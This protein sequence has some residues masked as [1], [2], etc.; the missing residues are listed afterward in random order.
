MSLE[1]KPQILGEGRS[2]IVLKRGDIAIKVFTG[3]D[4]LTKL[5]NYIF[6]GAPNACVWN[7]DAAW[8]AHY[9]REIL[10]ELVEHWFDDKLRVARSQGVEWNDDFKAYELHT[11]FV[12][13]RPA[14]LH[15]PYSESREGELSDLVDNVMK[16]LQERLV[17]AGFDG[18]VWQAGKGNPVASNNF[19][20]E[21]KVDGGLHW[22]WIDIESGVPALFPLNP[23]ALFSFYIPKSIKHRHALFDDVDIEKLRDY[24]ENEKHSLGAERYYYLIKG[25]E[26]LAEHQEKWK[27]TRRVDRSIDYRFKKG[28]ITE[29]QRELYSNY[30]FVW[31]V[32][33]GARALWKG[34]DKILGDLPWRAFDKLTTIDYKEKML[35]FFRFIS[36]EQEG[37][38]GGLRS[39]LGKMLSKI[40]NTERFVALGVGWVPIAGNMAYPVQMIYSASTTDREIGKFMVYDFFSAIGENIPIWGGENTRTH[41]WFNRIPDLIVRDR[42]MPDPSE[43]G[44]KNV[45]Y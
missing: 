17:E 21:D 7:E 10:S 24:V 1:E 23:L 43:R 34:Y 31:Y 27:S 38:K 3:G 11:E 32:R 36:S 26:Q 2:G 16:P 6:C 18:S 28:E 45:Q 13:G 20:L 25:V 15:H 40:I 12:D 9:R 37:L 44:D 29:T 22:A 14:S 4:S 42:R 41:H 19:L 30:P 39:V 8:A 5:V 35:N 33:E